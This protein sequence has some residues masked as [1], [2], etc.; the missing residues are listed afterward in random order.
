MPFAV[1]VKMRVDDNINVNGVGQ[2]CP[3]HM[4]RYGGRET[5]VPRVARDD[6]LNSG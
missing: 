2:E 3:T 5:K 4:G 6:N 1:R